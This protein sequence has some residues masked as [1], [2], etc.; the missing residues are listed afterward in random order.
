MVVKTNENMARFVCR[1]A[2]P[3]IL[4]FGRC[5]CAYISVF[6]VDI[7]L[8]LTNIRSIELVADTYTGAEC[9]LIGRHGN[10]ILIGK[11]ETLLNCDAAHGSIGCAGAG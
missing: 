6:I 11:R 2:C 9:V 10:F 5:D 8:I 4:S 1:A 3:H 7:N